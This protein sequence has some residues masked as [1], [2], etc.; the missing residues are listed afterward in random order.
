MI[1][2]KYNPIRCY[3]AIVYLVAFVVLILDLFVW[4]K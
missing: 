3:L 2:M 1:Y 4:R